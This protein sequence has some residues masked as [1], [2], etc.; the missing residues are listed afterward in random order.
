MFS[1]RLPQADLLQFFCLPG[2]NIL[3]LVLLFPQLRQL[4]LLLLLA[5]L[6]VSR[7]CQRRIRTFNLV[8]NP[9]DL[10]RR[11]VE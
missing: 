3:D 8:F 7:T 6:R 2:Q 9:N 5:H 4:L 10:N 11:V 1:H